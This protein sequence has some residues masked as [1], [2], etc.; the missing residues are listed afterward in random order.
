MVR[1]ENELRN[2]F[3]NGWMEMFYQ[4]RVDLKTGKISGAE[5]LIRCRDP[6]KGIVPPKDFIPLAEEIG[7][8]GPITLWALDQVCQQQKKWQDAGIQIVPVSVNLVAEQFQDDHIITVLRQNSEKYQLSSQYLEVELTESAAMQHPEK[9]ADL[10]N[11]IQALGILIAI[12]DFGTGYSSLAYLEK[13]PIN[14]L[15]IDISFVQGVTTDPHS[16]AI[17]SAIIAMSKALQ[18]LIVAEGVETEGQRLFLSEHHCEEGQG[19]LFSKPL[20]ANDFESLLAGDIR[21]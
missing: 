2:A 15:K 9:T 19:F 13:F 17:T 21:Y 16:A 18:F 10:L 8:I 20:P 12:D 6:E 5:A 4:P 11:Q 7:L 14:I 1:K 3:S